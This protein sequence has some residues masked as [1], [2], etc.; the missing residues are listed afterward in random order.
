MRIDMRS[1]PLLVVSCDKYADL[2]PVFLEI[3]YNRWQDCPFPIYIGSNTL[4]ASD[5]R[6]SGIM[7]GVDRSWSENLLS[8]LNVL[9][10]EYVLL[11]LEDFLIRKTVD[12]LRV[13][14]IIKY[15]VAHKVDCT[16]LASLLSPTPLPQLKLAD[17]PLLGSVAPGT[18]YRVSAQI[19]LWR[20]DALKHYLVPGFTAW[21]F[22]HLGTQ[23]STYTD[24]LF[25]GP[26]ESYIDYDHGVEKGRWKP[27]GLKI[28]EDAGVRVDLD[29]RPAFSEDE[30]CM[31][32]SSGEHAS[33]LADLKADALK[34]YSSG[35]RLD[36][37]RQSYRYLVR[38]RS[39]MDILFISCFGLIGAEAL[40]WLRRIH[41]WLKLRA[42]RN[43]SAKHEK[44]R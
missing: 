12:S 40:A 37:I 11:F 29:K 18:P 36:G 3:F 16:R 42:V 38:S 19:A 13:Q 28:C 31:H 15:S 41:L 7:V 32:F 39:S 34:A 24:H 43:R 35:H 33:Q 5:D 22:E 1:I 25:L 26:Y 10:S 6:V 4:E 44:F 9:S 20:V 17:F 8:M 23:M 27:D 14:E 21:E 30:L 2:W